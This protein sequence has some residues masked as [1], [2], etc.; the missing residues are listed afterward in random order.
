MPLLG[1]HVQ[2]HGPL[3]LPHHAQ[4][5]LQLAD[6]VSGGFFFNAFWRTIVTNQA[7]ELDKGKRRKQRF[8]KAPEK[9]RASEMI[10]GLK[11]FPIGVDKEALVDPLGIRIKFRCKNRRMVVSRKGY[12]GLVPF[13]IERDDLVCVLLGGDM[14]FI[15]RPEG[16]YYALVGECY[17]HENGWRSPGGGTRWIDPITRVLFAI[18]ILL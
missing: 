18:G 7:F 9:D 15:L 2:Q 16:N 8:V 1:Y 17:V 6:V 11:D 4:V 3:E 14:P 12:L 10:F 5:L 13:E